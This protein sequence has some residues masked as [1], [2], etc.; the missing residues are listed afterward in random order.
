MPP[1]P[2]PGSARPPRRGRPRRFFLRSLFLSRP[3]SLS[4][5][6]WGRG[7]AW[8][9]ARGSLLVVFLFSLDLCLPGGGGAEP[10]PPSQRLPG[11]CRPHLETLRYLLLVSVKLTGRVGRWT[12]S[13]PRPP[14][15]Y[16]AY[17]AWRG[18][19]ETRRTCAEGA[20]LLLRVSLPAGLPLPGGVGGK[21]G[22]PRQGCGSL[23]PREPG[24]GD[25]CPPPHR[26]LSLPP[27][28]SRGAGAWGAPQAA[29]G[30]AG[31]GA[32]PSGLLGGLCLGS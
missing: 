23:A 24:W 11:A 22:S 16:P 12:G 20:R 25:P 4:A 30:L 6:A 7:R 28:S 27:L 29:G 13:R 15:G 21:S 9:A 1:G 18:A 14:P 5:H 31:Q 8:E 19:G 26:P 2:R 3:H 10:P 32:L 17:W